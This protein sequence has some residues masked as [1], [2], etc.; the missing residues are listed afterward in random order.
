MPRQQQAYEAFIRRLQEEW[1]NADPGASLSSLLVRT[2][3][4]LEAAGELTRDEWA[5]IRE[6]VRRDLRDFEDA[7]GGYRDSAFYQALQTSI[8]AWLLELTDRTQVEWIAVLDEVQHK[9]LYHAGERM[10]LGTL[11]CE[12]CGFRRLVLHP[13]R[14]AT[15]IECGGAHFHREPLAP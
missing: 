11:V 10:G 7:P 13:E 4:Y 15:C 8:W 12:Q 3:A 14:I 9:G 1:A 2:Q 6:Y 5:L